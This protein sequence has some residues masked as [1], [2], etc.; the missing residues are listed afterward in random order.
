MGESGF[1]LMLVFCLRFP[2]EI[3]NPGIV[4][5]IGKYEKRE[6]ERGALVIPQELTAEACDHDLFV[7]VC[8]PSGTHS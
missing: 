1:L 2:R 3:S 5:A 7:Q 8:D 4:R 6:R